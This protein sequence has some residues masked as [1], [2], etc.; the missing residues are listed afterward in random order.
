MDNARS[1]GAHAGAYKAGRPTYPD[2]LFDWLAQLSP[3]REAV[4]D[5][6]TGSGQA[7]LALAERFDRVF[8][9][10]V[11]AAQLEQAEPHPHIVYRVAPA[12]ASGLPDDSA[13]L[14]TA[15]TALHWFAGKPFW[16]EVRRVGR[17]G[18]MFAGWVYSDIVVPQAVEEALVEPVRRLI[19]PFWAEGNRIAMAGYTAAALEFPFAEVTAPP[20]AVEVSWNAERLI[21]YLRTWS[22]HTRGMKEPSL[23]PRL[24]AAEEAA[25]DRFGGEPFEVRM[26]LSLIVG[27]VG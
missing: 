24:I 26:P 7:A 9:T 10:D 2:A 17:P 8:A 27:R 18:S 5:C 12:E 16:D 25:L 20:F 11:D 15:A 23:A 22:A 3:A 14:I 13:D 19:D 6:A 4:W 1:F 21:A